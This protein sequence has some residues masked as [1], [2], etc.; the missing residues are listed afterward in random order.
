MANQQSVLTDVFLQ[1]WFL[2]LR[3][4][5]KVRDLITPD[6]R[7]KMRFYFDD[8]GCLKCGKR[9]VRYGSNAMCKRCVQSVKLKM[10]FAIKRRW[11]SGHSATEPPQTFQRA[12]IARNLLADLSPRK[13]IS[14]RSD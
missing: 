12:E 2:S 1:P 7:H 14:H 3:T 13:R 11:Q 10:L 4:A 9:Q 8:Y 6:H 5:I